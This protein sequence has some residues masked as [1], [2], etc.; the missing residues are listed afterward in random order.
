MKTLVILL[1]VGSCTLPQNTSRCIQS[2]T[3]KYKTRVKVVKT[4]RTRTRER[5]VC[6]RYVHIDT[7]TGRDIPGSEFK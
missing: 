5:A 2:H 3:E 4:Y 6:D 1:F 7:L